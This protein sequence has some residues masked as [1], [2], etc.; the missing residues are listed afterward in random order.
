MQIFEKFVISG[1]CS[2]L[3]NWKIIKW[4]L[5]ERPGG[6]E[7]GVLRAARTCIPFSGEYPH[8][9]SLLGSRATGLFASNLGQGENVVWCPFCVFLFFFNSVFVFVSPERDYG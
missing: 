8:Y 4:G 3:R 5:G 2:A 6:C 7:N 1:E 9:V